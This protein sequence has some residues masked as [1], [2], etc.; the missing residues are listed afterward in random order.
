MMNPPEAK[1]EE[2]ETGLTQAAMLEDKIFLEAVRSGDCSR[3]KSSFRDGLKTLK[4]SLAVNE[5]IRTGKAVTLI[6]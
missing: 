5:S 4:V 2:Y 6:S 3:I 1:V